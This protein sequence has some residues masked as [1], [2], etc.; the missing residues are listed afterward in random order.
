MTRG[1][2][3]VLM[4]LLAACGSESDPEPGRFAIP[5]E[6]ILDVFGQLSS[7]HEAEVFTGV[8]NAVLSVSGRYLAIADNSSPFVKVL[9]REKRQ[10][11]GLGRDGDGPGELR[12]A[13]ALEFLGDSVLVVLDTNQ[14][15][16]RLGVNGEWQSTVNMAEHGIHAMSITLG[17]DDRFFV[18]GV[19]AVQSGSGS[20][21]WLHEVDLLGGSPT[22]ARLI[23][24][25]G[26]GGSVRSGALFGLD[27]TGEGVMVW[28]RQLTSDVEAGYW[29]PCDGSEPFVLDHTAG[30]QTVAE[31]FEVGGQQAL[32]LTLPDTLFSGAAAQGSMGVRAFRWKDGGVAVTTIQVMQASGCGLLELYG[33]WRLFDLHMDELVLASQDPFPRAVVVNWNWI[34]QSLT[35]VRCG[36]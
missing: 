35:P 9:D 12:S 21:P 27:G 26:T 7:E 10:A 1:S 23:V 24:P 19:P 28:H 13:W 11:W 5:E 31:A 6:Q 2:A 15:L 33:N 34:E 4:L 16:T 18:Y 32:V 25:G 20:V 8:R 22:I 17:C 14:R 3:L 29:V 30:K 36:A